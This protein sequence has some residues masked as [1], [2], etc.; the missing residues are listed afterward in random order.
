MSP[1][2][3]S[4]G[5]TIDG[6][7]DIFS[8]GVV[9]IELISGVHPLAPQGFDNEN[10]FTFVRKIVDGPP[11][12]LRAFAH[13]VPVH[14]ADV[15]DKA[16]VRDQRLRYGSAAEFGAALDGALRRLESDVGTAEPL[17]TL[18]AEL[19]RLGD[20]AAPATR[21]VAGTAPL[22]VPVTEDADTLV[23]RRDF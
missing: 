11:V 6:R 13:W 8:L 20:G 16:V 9:L 1:E 3:A 5:D 23:M 22:A 21:L 10:M 4:A 12:V 17:E 2:Q 7:S 15:L 18:V 19:N 14:V